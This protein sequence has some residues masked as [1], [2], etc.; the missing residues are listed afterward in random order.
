MILVMRAVLTLVGLV[1]ILI[2]TS[3]LID[4]A[5]QGGDFGLVAKGAQGLSTIRADFTAYFW[6][7]GGTL[8]IGAWKRNGDLLLVAAALMGITLA[9][10]GLSLAL[11]GFYEGWTMPMAVEAFTVIVAL[12]GSRVLPHSAL[13]PDAAETL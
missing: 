6:V 11:D 10:R 1:F 12:F 9:V 5:I 8:V 4:P 13:V 3:F 2:G 7:A